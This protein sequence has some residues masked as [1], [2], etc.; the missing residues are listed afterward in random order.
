[1]KRIKEVKLQN[2]DRLQSSG[3]QATM[4]SERSSHHSLY[5]NGSKKNLIENEELITQN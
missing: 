3:A 1:M 5:K 4:N 2:V